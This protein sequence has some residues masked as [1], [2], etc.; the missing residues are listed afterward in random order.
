[1]GIPVNSR[2]YIEL[3]VK[4]VTVQNVAKVYSR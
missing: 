3:I 4:S 2:Y 1:M